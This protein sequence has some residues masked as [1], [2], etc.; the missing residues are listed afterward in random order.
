MA[1]IF[2][3]WNPYKNV[4]ERRANMTPEEISSAEEMWIFAKEKGLEKLPIDLERLLNHLNIQLEYKSL[5]DGISGELYRKENGSWKI[6]VNSNQTDARKRFTIAHEQG[7]YVLHRSESDV[8]AD[9]IFFRS[10]EKDLSEYQA[11]NFAAELLMPKELFTR[12]LNENGCTIESLSQ[13]FGVSYVATR[14]RLNNI[15]P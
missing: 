12:A 15:M 5:D 2:G 8:F 9:E 1:V 3:S 6:V 7:H 4:Q 11:D 10:G 13:R 14:V